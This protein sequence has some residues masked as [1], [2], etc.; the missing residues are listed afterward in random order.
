MSDIPLRSFGR[1]SKSRTGYSALSGEV[2]SE[3]GQGSMT[4]N[5]R[6]A[7][8]SAR[9]TRQ[10][11]RRERYE[12]DPEEEATLLGE[13]LRDGESRDLEDE[14]HEETASQVPK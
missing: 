5:S 4:M 6:V 2:Q 3:S 9:T 7:A 14:A 8:A 13:E 11:K 1:T 12:D 10:G